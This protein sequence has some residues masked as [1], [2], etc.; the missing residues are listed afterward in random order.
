MRILNFNPLIFSY[1]RICD[2]FF[3]DGNDYKHIPYLTLVK[4]FLKGITQE[5]KINLFH[6]YSSAKKNIY[7]MD[8]QNFLK[9]QVDSCNIITKY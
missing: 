4:L 7:K 2:R 1:S 6:L 5:L 8:I 9:T 3:W